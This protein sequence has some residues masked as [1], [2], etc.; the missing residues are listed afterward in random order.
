[1]VKWRFEFLTQSFCKISFASIHFILI[2]EI[3]KI[4]PFL[5]K[6]RLREWMR[7]VHGFKYDNPQLSGP[8]VTIA[9]VVCLYDSDGTL[10][11]LWD[12]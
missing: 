2:K 5:I 6:M 3:K 4:V 12:K 10:L 7:G 8:R 1:M 11:S 9:K